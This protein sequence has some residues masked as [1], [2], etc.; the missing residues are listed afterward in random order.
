ML[1][2]LWESEVLC[3]KAVLRVTW[4][5]QD[6]CV[7]AEDGEGGPEERELLVA[8]A[9]KVKEEPRE[10]QGSELVNKAFGLF[11]ALFGNYDYF[12]ELIFSRIGQHRHRHTEGKLDHLVLRMC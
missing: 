5:L 11:G 8:G 12:C 9:S 2:L 10:G 7:A 4:G 1:Y 3:H 6:M